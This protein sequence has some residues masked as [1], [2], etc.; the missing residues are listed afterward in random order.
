MTGATKGKPYT[1]APTV[2]GFEKSDEPLSLVAATL[3]LII[4]PGT[5]L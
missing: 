3:T 5:K 4:C 1:I 2:L